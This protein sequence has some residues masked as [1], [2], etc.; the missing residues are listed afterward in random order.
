MAAGV[1]VALAV[2][3]W[4][5]TYRVY[6]GQ[7]TFNAL[8]LIYIL[9]SAILVWALLASAKGRRFTGR[10]TP[11]RVVAIV[12]T[13]NEDPAALHA[14]VRALLSGTIVPDEIHVVDDGSDEAAPLYRHPR[15]A[16]HRQRNGGKRHAQALV[17][18]QLASR[19]QYRPDF[20]LTVDSDSVVDRRAVEHLLRAMND[21]RVQ[22]ATGLPLVR[23]HA[24]SWVTRITD[25]EMVSACLTM[26]AAR[27]TLG[28]V[29]PCSG[30][31]ALYRAPIVLDNLD[32]YVTSGTAGDD[33]RLTHYALLRGH[34]VAVDDA[35]VHTDMPHTV[36]GVYRQRVRWFSSYWRYARWEIVHLPLVPFLWR[37]Y[38]LVLGLVVPIA[39][40][41]I[42]VAAALGYGLAWHG[43]VFWA[44][45]LW[46]STLRYAL[47]RPQMPAWHRLGIWLI[48][49]PM[50]MLAQLLVL[51]P[52]M[53]H[54]IFT[55]RSSAW[56]TRKASAPADSAE[57]T[58]ELTRYLPAVG[59]LP[60]TRGARVGG[61]R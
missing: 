51:R 42:V 43:L 60:R 15:V 9:T 39:L 28:A 5:I 27:S 40:V 17:L 58:A 53:L 35:L 16:W 13:F 33:R 41:W 49:T 3:A 29:A 38:A 47:S 20:I 55:A 34:A 48:G 46:L 52:S 10:P 59:S 36:R 12:P 2:T 61:Q 44:A 26:R 7:K 22:A 31:L 21:H 24:R 37:A 18:R 19:R 14:T 45:I 56:G 1:I 8:L 54:A 11:G 30:A 25:L 4:I 32:D 50:L 23:N 57:T 6:I